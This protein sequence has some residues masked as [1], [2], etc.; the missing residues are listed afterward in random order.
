MRSSNNVVAVQC[1][2]DLEEALSRYSTAF[3][4]VALRQ[5]RN[6]EDAEDAV[7]DALLSAVKHI[8]QFQGR[9]HISTWLYR[10]VINSARMQLRRSHP[11]FLS[12]DERGKSS[13]SDFAHHLADSGLNP[14]Q[15][16]EKTELSEIVAQLLEN[17]SPKLR[18][19]V[20]LRHL[21]GLS[22]VESARTLGVTGNTLK[23][24]T[25]RARIKL[26]LLLGE[27]HSRERGIET[28]QRPKATLC[29]RTGKGILRAIAVPM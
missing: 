4:R 25:Q 17:L 13:D 22:T 5:L 8:S 24:R 15:V 6:H 21:N 12:L 9:S 19:A 20:E 10:I 7:Q 16:Y 14:E 1:P 3:Y 27:V 23:S 28:L 29:G 26:R 11:V 2:K 18:N